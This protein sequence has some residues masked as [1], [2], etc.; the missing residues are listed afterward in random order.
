MGEKTNENDQPHRRIT[1]H[2]ENRDSSC[3]TRHP[4]FTNRLRRM[5]A[6]AMMRY[7]LRTGS[8]GSAIRRTTVLYTPFLDVAPLK[9]SLPRRN[10]RF[11]PRSE[12]AS[13]K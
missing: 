12:Y 5:Y 8:E 7:A 11:P 9:M 6:V 4:P 10:T 1:R 2:H 3:S 13:L